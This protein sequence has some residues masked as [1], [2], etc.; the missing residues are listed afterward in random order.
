[1]FNFNKALLSPFHKSYHSDADVKIL[2]ESRTVVRIG[3]INPLKKR[4]KAITEIDLTR[5][6][7]QP[8]MNDNKVI[9]SVHRGSNQMQKYSSNEVCVSGCIGEGFSDGSQKRNQIACS[10]IRCHV[11]CRNTWQKIEIWHW[12]IA[13][14]HVPLSTHEKRWACTSL[15]ASMPA[16]QISTHLVICG[17]FACFTVFCL[18]FATLQ[19]AV[20][21]DSPSNQHRLATSKTACWSQ[22]ALHSGR[23]CRII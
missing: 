13:K 21:S 22:S 1:M 10:T 16:H 14:S 11:S 7:T 20:R 17:R 19:R 15:P 2:N 6:F 3:V 9:K 4:P 8:F 12:N 23:K 5:V 18:R